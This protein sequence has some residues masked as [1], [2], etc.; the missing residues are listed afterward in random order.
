M[1]IKDTSGSTALTVA[2]ESDSLRNLIL[3]PDTSALQCVQRLL[4]AGARINTGYQF[5]TLFKVQASD[6]E[7]RILQVP[8]LLLAAGERLKREQI[9]NVKYNP[10]REIL[11][12]TPDSVKRRR[13]EMALKRPC[14]KRIRKHLLELDL[15]RN[16]FLRVH[17]L[18]LPKNLTSY[19]VHQVSLDTQLW[20][21]NSDRDFW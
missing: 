6:A 21:C 18:P 10:E 9:K 14:R 11:L 12:S 8:A 17:Q 7:K 4:K 16:L 2:V 5:K 20:E 3:D 1:N 13:R 15:H 19:L